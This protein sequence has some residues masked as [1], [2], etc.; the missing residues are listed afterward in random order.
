MRLCIEIPSSTGRTTRNVVR[1]ASVR[2]DVNLAAQDGD[3]LLEA[4]PGN[5]AAEWPRPCSV[6]ATGRRAERQTGCGLAFFP[7]MEESYLATNMTSRSRAG[8]VIEWRPGEE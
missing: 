7:L 5:R 1:P 4:L 8:P 2:L 6:Q 3:G